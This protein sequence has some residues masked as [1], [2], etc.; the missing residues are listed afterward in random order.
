MVHY[1]VH[2]DAT[3][4]AQSGV[5]NVWSAEVSGQKVNVAVPPEFSGPGGGFS[6]EDLYAL[7]LQNCFIAT[8]K[9]LAERSRMEFS[10]LDVKATL[11]VDRNEAGQPWMARINFDV[12]LGGVENVAKANRVLKKTESSC[13]ILNSVKTEKSFTYHFEGTQ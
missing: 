13:F 5:K 3:A 4:H 7:A 10:D 12:R 9:V 6:P 1:P 2:F 8:F 11:A